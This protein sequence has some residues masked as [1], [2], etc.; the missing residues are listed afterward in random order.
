MN[1]EI[2]L[3]HTPGGIPVI[4]ESLPRSHSASFS[5]YFGT[6]SRDEP[7]SQAGIAHMLEHM[8]FKGTHR[9]TAQQ[10]AE[11]IEG[12]GGEQ[13]GYTTNEVTSYHAF[14]LD[15]TAEVAEDVLADMVLHPRLDPEC[16]ATEKNVVIQEIRMLENDPEDYIH[17]LFDEA[18]WGDHPMGRSEAGSVETVSALS[19]GD[20]RSFFLSHYR[21]PRMAVVAVGNI[22]ERQVTD[23]AARSF[24]GLEVSENGRERKPPEPMARFRVFPRNDRQAYVGMGFPG[25]SSVHPDRYAQRLMASVLGSGTSSR[26]FQEIRER[27]GLVYEI[28]AASHSFTDCGSMDVFYNT[29]VKDQEKVARLVAKEIGRMKS[30]GLVP[31]E[32]E[33]AKRLVKGVYVRRLE[34]TESRMVRLGESFM[35]SG[36]ILSPEAVLARMDA[37]TDEDVIGAAERLLVRDRLCIA[38]HAPGK[39]SEA[40]A[41]NL[42]DLDF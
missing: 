41:G 39:E 4:I 8:M 38:M 29:S 21:P 16:L 28:Y 22:D 5:V 17:V 6:G 36:E 3:L 15:E 18:L 13:N 10:M 26:L 11:E 7:A 9:R 30:E 19:E 35:S 42:A 25:L 20:I 12:A 23:W 33:R 14:S 37:V 32:L 40:A 27:S 2:K 34:S 1:S 31:G 24:D